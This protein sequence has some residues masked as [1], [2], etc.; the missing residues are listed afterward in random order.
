VVL[1]IRH[2]VGTVIAKKKGMRTYL[3]SILF[4]FVSIFTPLLSEGIQ[5]D[6]LFSDFDVDNSTPDSKS[7][8]LLDTLTRFETNSLLQFGLINEVKALKYY[9]RNNFKIPN[10]YIFRF[11]LI[12]KKIG[13]QNYSTEIGGHISKYSDLM[14]SMGVDSAFFN[15]PYER[16][17]EF[18]LDLTKI[19]LNKSLDFIGIVD[20]ASSVPQ[21]QISLNPVKNHRAVVIPNLLVD[22][23]L[24]RSTYPIEIVKPTQPSK[25][26]DRT[27][28][29]KRSSFLNI[30]KKIKVTH[31]YGSKYDA[32]IQS[33]VSD[34]LAKLFRLN[35]GDDLGYLDTRRIIRPE[36]I[37]Q[38]II[39]IDV[40]ILDIKVTKA[41]EVPS[42]ISFDIE[43][44]GKINN[45]SN[46]SSFQNV[47][48]EANLEGLEAFNSP[49][50][51]ITKITFR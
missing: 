17:N 25:S 7:K 48:A 15:V 41:S 14:E 39:N 45:E 32:I 22:A 30:P 21:S 27:L 12:F 38:T 11:Y 10:N 5:C 19:D 42:K 46:Y 6:R 2:F 16:L 31:S 1:L 50:S 51:G 8:V 49:S 18:I 23:Q 4:L 20:P 36:F 40:R 43:I 35:L 33:S 34:I 26:E 24:D 13:E 3:I 9:I 44:K 37:F 28:V 29:Y 47:S